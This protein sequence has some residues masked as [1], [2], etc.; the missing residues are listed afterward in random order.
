MKG[1]STLQAVGSGAAGALALT[2]LHESA[3]RTHPDA[4]RMDVLGKRAI[5]K[6]LKRMGRR[7]PE[8]DALHRMTLLG[9]IA[10]N[11]LYYS[12]VGAGRGP[13]VWFRGGLLGLLAGIGGVLLP[14]KMRLGRRPSGRTSRTKW[15]TVVWYLTGGLAAAAV[16]SL[17]TRFMREDTEG[18]SATQG[19]G[20]PA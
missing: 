5:V 10:A 2:A 17:L 7:P 20:A 1:K 18:V 14:G 9:D 12:L 15:M 4:P 11:S 8:P 19:E 16:S 3:R 13:W 6:G